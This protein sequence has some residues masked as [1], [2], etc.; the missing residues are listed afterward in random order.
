[1]KHLYYIEEEDFCG[2]WF[3]AIAIKYEVGYC[4]AFAED[5]DIIEVKVVYLEND[6][7]TILG[8]KRGRLDFHPKWI[9]LLDQEAM[10]FV[11]KYIDDSEL[12]EHAENYR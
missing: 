3:A 5:V 9:N 7:G 2:K 8:G 12:L 10:K 11:L 4:D 1:M 6:Q